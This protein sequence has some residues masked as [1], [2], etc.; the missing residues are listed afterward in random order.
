MRLQKVRQ[1]IINTAPLHKL[2]ASTAQ[3]PR[4]KGRYPHSVNRRMLG[5]H[6]VSYRMCW[7]TDDEGLLTMSCPRPL[8]VAADLLHTPHEGHG[9][10][11]EGNKVRPTMVCPPLP[12]R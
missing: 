2:G 7:A 1:S 4:R 12:F 5:I 8:M 6:P 9:P 3:V 11:R 10:I